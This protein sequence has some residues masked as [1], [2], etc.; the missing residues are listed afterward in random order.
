MQFTFAIITDGN[1]DERVEK[2]IDSILSN[3]I[4]KNK[5]EIIIIGTSKIKHSSCKII[6][7]SER[8]PKNAISIKKNVAAICARFE[9][10]VLL[11][12]YVAFRNDWY[13]NFVTFGNDWDVCVTRI[14]NT[15][16]KRFRDWFKVVGGNPVDILTRHH[17]EVHFGL[18][19]VPYEDTNHIRNT[20]VSGTYFVVKKNFLLDYPLDNERKWGEGEDVEW[21]YR[22][23]QFWNYK[24][25]PKSEVFFLKDKNHYPQSPE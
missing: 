14:V 5:Y 7:T 1:S 15:D 13:K 4:P 23:N 2:I 17:S 24:V 3:D 21:S 25:N 18:E 6:D 19:F 16:G 9:N 10:I 12:D 20:Y 22:V 8:V 11:H